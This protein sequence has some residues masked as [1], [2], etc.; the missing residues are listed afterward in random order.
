MQPYDL[1][2]LVERSKLAAGKSRTKE[3]TFISHLNDTAWTH[4]KL[5][6]NMDGSKMKPDENKQD[7]RG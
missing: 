6:F 5:A 2:A 4:D 3:R 1:K 7:A